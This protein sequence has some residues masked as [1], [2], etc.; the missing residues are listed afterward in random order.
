MSPKTRRDI[1][2]YF[3]ISAEQDNVE[4]AKEIYEDVYNKFDDDYSFNEL[5]T[6]YFAKIGDLDK[7]ANVI[8]E[9][10]FRGVNIGQLAIEYITLILHYERDFDQLIDVVKRAE[11][12]EPRFLVT[13]YDI[14]LN[15]EKHDY[16]LY[17]LLRIEKDPEALKEY[18]SEVYIDIVN[19]YILLEDY[20]TATDV[21]ANLEGIQTFIFFISLAESG[22]NDL[23]L[24]LT[25]LLDKGFD[26]DWVNIIRAYNLLSLGREDESYELVK[27]M[28]NTKITD[29][30][31]IVLLAKMLARFDELENALELFSGLQGNKL[32]ECKY[33]ALFLSQIDVPKTV[34]ILD[35]YVEKYGIPENPEIFIIIADEFAKTNNLDAIIEIMGKAID[36]YPLDSVVLNYYGYS[37][38]ERTE[39]E[40]HYARVSQGYYG[41]KLL[42][43]T[44]GFYEAGGYLLSALGLSPDS[45][46]IQ[47]SVAWFFYLIGDYEKALSYM[48]GNIEAAKENSEI[49]YHIGMIYYRLEDFESA[50]SHFLSA[51]AADTDKSFVELAVKVYINLN[52]ERYEEFLKEIDEK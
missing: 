18:G 21:L 47:D 1:P 27:G 51:I 23:D 48:K 24:I 5:I 45:L 41:E 44:K 28:A 36:Y 42:K 4:R 34:K 31:I 35:E 8:L 19:L 32:E 52:P 22:D 12:I 33:K 6:F 29:E 15:Y 39:L 2:T 40:Y 38:L 11:D 43:Y 46:E 50:S 14:M 26:A 20:D 13:L 10:L 9:R 7:V 16:A 37:L 30:Y 3:K 25:K 17:L 49:D